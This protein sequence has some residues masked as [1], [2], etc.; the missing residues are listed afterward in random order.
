MT[1]GSWCRHHDKNVITEVE[2]IHDVHDVK[3]HGGEKKYYTRRY[4]EIDEA[5]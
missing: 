1:A 3:W 4:K 2:K 5:Y